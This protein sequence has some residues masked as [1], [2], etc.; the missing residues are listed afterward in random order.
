MGYLME[1][2]SSF[3]RAFRDVRIP[4]FPTL[5]V[6]QQLAKDCYK[7]PNQMAAV[8]GSEN[9][10]TQSVLGELPRWEVHLFL[11]H[12]QCPFSFASSF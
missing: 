12:L 1:C 11:V 3:T 7:T 8:S 9:F 5:H 6:L 4:D 2:K 10:L